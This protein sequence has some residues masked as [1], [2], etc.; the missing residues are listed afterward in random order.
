[1]TEIADE[2]S[3]WSE[4]GE[5]MAEGMSETKLSFGGHSITVPLHGWWAKEGEDGIVESDS[6]EIA[7]RVLAILKARASGMRITLVAA[8]DEE[9]GIGRNG[10]LPWRCPEDLRHFK[11]RTLGRTLLMGRITFEGL[12][13]RLEGRTIHVVSRGGADELTSIDRALAWLCSTGVDEIVVA[14]GG[15]L[16][17]AALPFCTHAEV[18]RI[19]GTHGC[20]AFMPDLGS[21]DWNLESSAQLAGD[22]RIQYWEVNQ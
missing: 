9:W 6:L 4:T 12:P 2:T 22:I 13:R 10:A 11:A 21:R 17:A 8:A 5:Q 7:D 19:P 15:A 16:Y 18:T 14:G 3:R 1:M 20:D